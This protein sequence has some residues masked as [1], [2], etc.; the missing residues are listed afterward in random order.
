M[1]RVKRENIFILDDGKLVEENPYT[2]GRDVASI[3]YE[4]FGVEARPKDIQ[5]RLNECF[6]LLENEEFDKATAIIKELTTILGENDT[7]VM[8][9]KLELELNI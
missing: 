2:Y 9:A 7:D 1:S 3:L 6:R 5:K 4:V 8:R